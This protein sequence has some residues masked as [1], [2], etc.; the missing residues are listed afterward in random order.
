MLGFAQKAG[1]VFSGDATVEAKISK[2]GASLVI[3]ASDAPE[4]TKKRKNEASGRSKE[5]SHKNLLA[6]NVNWES[7]LVNH[8]EM[9]FL[10]WMRDSPE[11][12]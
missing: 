5:D 9:W 6:K 3:V 8:R 11:R 12:L 4:N 1:K 10:S 2:R 7:L